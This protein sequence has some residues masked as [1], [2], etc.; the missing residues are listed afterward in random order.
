VEYA[1]Q[2]SR[3]VSYGGETSPRY[4]EAAKQAAYAQDQAMEVRPASVLEGICYQAD[5]INAE[6]RQAVN[7]AE[8]LADRLIGCQPEAPCATLGGS[9]NQPV[10]SAL[11]PRLQNEQDAMSSLLSRLHDILHR[12]DNLG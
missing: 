12:L 4:A 5:A 2:K 7:R 6:L 8:N 10:P 11:L 9:I 3:D 1:N